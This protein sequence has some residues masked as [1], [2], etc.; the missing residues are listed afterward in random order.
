MEGEERQIHWQMGETQRSLA[1]SAAHNCTFS[2]DSFS[3]S[4]ADNLALLSP[5]NILMAY[6]KSPEII[7]G[8]NMN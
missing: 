5:T 6:K 4:K 1:K 7:K 2:M 8:D 3:S